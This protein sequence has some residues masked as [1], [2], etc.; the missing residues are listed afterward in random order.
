M[1]E[2]GYNKIV[3][4]VITIVVVITIIVVINAMYKQNN[5]KEHNTIK[6]YSYVTNDGSHKIISKNIYHPKSLNEIIKIIKNS[7]NRKIRVSGGHHTFN[8]ISIS[9]DVTMRTTNLNKIIKL[10][11]NKKRVTVESGITLLKL[12]RYL[13]KQG[14]SISIL[15][16]IPFQTIA[17][18]ISTSTHGSTTNFGS[19][20][21]MIVDVTIVLANGNVI[22]IDK[23]HKY[24]KAVI[25]SLG[26]LGVIYSITIQCE[27][28]FTIEHKRVKMKLKDILD[29]Y[30]DLQNKYEFLQMYIFPFTNDYDCVVYLRKKIK[31]E[32]KDYGNILKRA[33]KNT[34][35]NKI[36]F[37]HNILTKNMEGQSY[38]EMEIGIPEKHI[39]S[40]IYDIIRLY[41]DYKKKY[42]YH[43]KY[44][45]LIRFTRAD[46]NS[47]LSMVSNRDT[48]FIDVF[49]E[50]ELHSDPILN[51][52][53]KEIHDSFIEKYGGRPHYGKKHYLDKSQMEKIYGKDVINKFNNIRKQMDPHRM[54]SNVYINKL[55]L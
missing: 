21:S 7:K 34:K 50:S 22:K 18:A 43:T 30:K 35:F 36:D 23:N 29:S 3:I 15:P 52:L 40:A 31:I 8:T 39:K 13:E 2:F 26:C 53:F 10:D 4:V 37:S 33:K 12:N 9:P 6:Q 55:L 51:K 42:K 17:G 1:M 28:L 14:L 44:S 19:M 5:N 25:T 16:A 46:T 27:D 47:L 38:T 45:I 54:F 20:S 24:Y 11:K 41:E 49:N 48:V 32:N